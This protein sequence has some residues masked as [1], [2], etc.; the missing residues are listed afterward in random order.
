MLKNKQL[1]YFK[2][3]KGKNM[4]KSN[5]TKLLILSLSELTCFAACKQPTSSSA[6]IS[7]STSEVTEAPSSSEKEETKVNWG[8]AEAPI[9]VADAINNMKDWTGT[10]WSEVEGY[11]T[12]K[13]VSISKSSYGDYN[14]VLESTLTGNETFELYGAYLQEGVNEPVAGSTITVKGHFTKYIKS[15]NSVI[16]YEVAFSKTNNYRPYII[17]SDAVAT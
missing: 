9:T 1:Y 12:G 14:A 5:L 2:F 4:K 17:A 16:K 7:P 15:D 3:E 10:E 8:T 13:I 6:P 11:L